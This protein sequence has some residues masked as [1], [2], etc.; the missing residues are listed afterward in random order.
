MTQN[1]VLAD[2]GGNGFKRGFLYSLECYWTWD[3]SILAVSSSVEVSHSS[4]NWKIDSEFL[5][6]RMKD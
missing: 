4:V 6:A 3:A 2:E 1:W 5:F